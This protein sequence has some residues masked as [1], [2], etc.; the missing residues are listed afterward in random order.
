MRANVLRP[1]PTTPHAQASSSGTGNVQSFTAPASAQA[2]LVSV[3]TTGCYMTFDGTT[4]SSS[5]GLFLPTGV[6]HFIPAAAG[7]TLKFASSAAA[8][9]KVNVAWLS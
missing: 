2:A 4:P 9:S 7:L 8:T 5:A 3:E 1:E 6:L